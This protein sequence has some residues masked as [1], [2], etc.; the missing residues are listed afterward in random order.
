MEPLASAYACL[1][2]EEKEGGVIMI[3][4]GGGTSDI[5][6]F[7]NKK[8]INTAVIPFGGESITNDLTKILN[9]IRKHAEEIKSVLKSF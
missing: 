3:D 9:I 2:E 6:V 4:I 8:L 1:S 7:K 5:A